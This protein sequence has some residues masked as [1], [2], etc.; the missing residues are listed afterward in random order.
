MTRL[1]LCTTDTVGDLRLVDS[2]MKES[3]RMN[4]TDYRKYAGSDNSAHCSTFQ[5][6]RHGRHGTL[7]QQYA[8]N[9]IDDLY[10]WWANGGAGQTISQG[11]KDF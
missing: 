10:G 3:Q 8:Y 11:R 7:R 1:M 9:R 2:F 4:L 6:K 5:L